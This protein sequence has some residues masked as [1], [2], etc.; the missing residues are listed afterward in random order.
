MA[1]IFFEFH[2]QVQ[3]CHFGNFSILPKWH[4]WTHAWNSKICF[5][6]KTSFEAFWKC[7]IQEI[8]ITF[9]RVRQIQDLGWSKYKLRLFLK[10]TF[11]E[12]ENS[13]NS[14]F[15]WIPSKPGKQ[16]WKLPFFWVFIIVK[17]QCDTPNIYTIS[18]FIMKLL[19]K[20]LLPN[21]GKSNLNNCC[22][23]FV[24]LK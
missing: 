5:G 21:F 3:K 17:K 14:G 16:N 2:A 13:F 24:C 4:C 18:R 20:R 7:H 6:Q 23:T 11:R 22:I 19:L 1:K 8:F 9:S 10:R 15:L 12:F